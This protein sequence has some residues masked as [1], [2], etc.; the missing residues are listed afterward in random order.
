MIS[1][2]G[3]HYATMRKI[4]STQIRENMTPNMTFLLQLFYV[5]MT[6]ELAFW[7]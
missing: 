2:H 5:M 4:P 3:L 1:T 6:H 7:R